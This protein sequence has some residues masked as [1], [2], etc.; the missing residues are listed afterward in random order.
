[1]T[2]VYLV[3]GVSGSGKSW[4]CR[5]VAHKFNYIPHDRCWV[6]PNRRPEEGLDPRWAPGAVSNHLEVLVAAAKTSQRPILT[7]CPFAER[8]LR[9]KLEAHGIRVVPFFVVEPPALVAQ[10]YFAREKKPIPKAALTRATTIRERAI[11]W[12]APA[13]SSDHILHLLQNIP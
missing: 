1:M 9:E 8:D 4:A 2:P 5:Q 13:G 6:H 7:E 11:E 10:R 12:K 3:C